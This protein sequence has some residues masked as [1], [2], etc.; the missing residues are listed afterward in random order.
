MTRTETPWGTWDPATPAE[1][2]DILAGTDRPWWFAGGY[3]IEFAVGR[4]YRDHADVD[5]LLLRR[6][7]ALIEEALPS[8]EWFA[9]DPPGTLRPW[10][11]GEELPAEVH[12][13][14]C[15]P[16]PDE[17]WRIQFMLDEAEGED[18]VS[19][20]EP[21]VRRPL[22]DLGRISADGLPYLAPE[23]QLFYKAKGLR[24]KDEQ[25]FEQALP[26]LTQAERDWLMAVLALTHGEHPW[27]RRIDGAE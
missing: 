27:I 7:Q 20:R 5:V 18:W 14:W 6:D 22:A 8:W 2:A 3:A 11:P 17:P 12:D 19:R 10:A 13:I 4:A 24:P 1:V 23:I 25:D 9:A 26:T 15:R 16:G 21:L